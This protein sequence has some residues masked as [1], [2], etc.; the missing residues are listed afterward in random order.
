MSSSSFE[1]FL[2]CYNFV[3]LILKRGRSP[4]TLREWVPACFSVFLN[5]FKH[6]KTIK[7]KWFDYN[8]VNQTLQLFCE[9][10][11]EH[12]HHKP[13]CKLKNKILALACNKWKGLLE[14]RRKTYLVCDITFE[15]NNSHIL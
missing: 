8:N 11:N 10:V 6:G 12:S 4:L 3:Q 13:F 2:H 9:K 15:C 7:K 1:S 14:I 5:V